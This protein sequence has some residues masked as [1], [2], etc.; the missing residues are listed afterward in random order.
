VI[1]HAVWIAN[2]GIH[3]ADCS[4]SFE[5]LAELM[6]ALGRYADRTSSLE[7]EQT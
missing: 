2:D 3:T 4:L 1:L 5:E 7:S 6:T